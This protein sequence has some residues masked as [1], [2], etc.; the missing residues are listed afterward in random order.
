MFHYDESFVFLKKW[1]R[2]ISALIATLM[3]YNYLL[4]WPPPSRNQLAIGLFGAVSFSLMAIFGN[5]VRG[6]RLLSAVTLLIFF[7][8]L[9]NKLV[10]HSA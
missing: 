4:P 6:T 7:V 3:V 2:V 1:Q 8:A 10:G 9:V 5:R